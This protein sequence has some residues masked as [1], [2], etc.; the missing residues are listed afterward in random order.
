MRFMSALGSTHFL[1][2]IAVP[3][4][5]EPC[6]SMVRLY[7]HTPLRKEGSSAAAAALG[8]PTCSASTSAAR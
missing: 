3:L 1:L 2:L 5:V 7:S 8:M 4:P 6:P